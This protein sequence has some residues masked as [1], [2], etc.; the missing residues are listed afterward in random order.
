MISSSTLGKTGARFGNQLFQYVFLRAVAKKLGVQ[1]YCP[2]WI[3]DQIFLLDDKNE[4]TEMFTAKFNYTEDSYRHGFNNEVLKIK[5]DTEI[6]GYFQSEKFFNKEDVS[7]WLSFNENLFEI[8]KNKYKNIDFNNATAIHVR[9]GDYLKPSLMF[10]AP[11]SSY[12]KKALNILDTKGDVL[13]FSEDSEI[14]KKYLGEISKNTV[15][16]E[17]NKDYE[18]FYLMTLCKNIVCSPSSFSWWAAYLNKNEDKKVI[19][20]E[21]WFI[22]FCPVK[23]NDIFIDGWIRLPAHR[24]VFD[25]YYVRYLIIKVNTLFKN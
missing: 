17:G 2:E 7:K 11:K 13:I 21:Y 22:P 18:D 1:F 6:S 12:F 15:F 4:K 14:T 16:I 25:N 20:P 8:V 23:N 5:D 3:G 9:L 10:Y 24:I 19:M